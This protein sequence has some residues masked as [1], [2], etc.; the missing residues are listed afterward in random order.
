MASKKD[1]E[2]LI[3]IN[4]R[5]LVMITEPQNILGQLDPEK[6]KV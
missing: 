5:Q 3:E 2:S 6:K 4:N 1:I